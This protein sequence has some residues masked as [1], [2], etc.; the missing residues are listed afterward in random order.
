MPEAHGAYEEVRALP[1]RAP[2]AGHGAHVPTGADGQLCVGTGM[3]SNE[4]PVREIH[5]PDSLS[6]CCTSR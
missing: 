5:M 3:I 2:M 4:S 1:A 6:R